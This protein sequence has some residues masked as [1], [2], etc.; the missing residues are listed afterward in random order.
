MKKA[1]VKSKRIW[2]AILL[3]ASALFM[4]LTALNS[5]LK[6]PPEDF[7]AL[8]RETEVRQLAP[9]ASNWLLNEGD[10][11]ALDELPGIGPTLA[12]RII[13]NR[14]ADGAFYFPEDVMEV[15]GVGIKT[16]RGIMTW[17]EEHPDRAYI[18]PTE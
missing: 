12:A 9:M 10:A 16:F 7:S 4:L 6:P 11:D 18:H 14:E 1:D 8:E 13:E 17:L 3:G 15:K 2:G 5:I